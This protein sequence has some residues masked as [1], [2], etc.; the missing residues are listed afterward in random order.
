MGRLVSY[1][2]SY[3]LSLHLCLCAPPLPP[4][5]LVTSSP[6]QNHTSKSWHSLPR[7]Y[8]QGLQ[9]ALLWIAEQRGDAVVVPHAADVGVPPQR[10]DLTDDGHPAQGAVNQL[11]DVGVAHLLQTE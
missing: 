9:V 10:E 3:I 5:I 8:L 7:L 4:R 11:Q 2:P 1:F 6:Y